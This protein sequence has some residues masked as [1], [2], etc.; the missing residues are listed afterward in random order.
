VLRA[1]PL[2]ACPACRAAVRPTRRGPA[3][4]LACAGCGA[5]Y[6]VEDGIPDLRV[7]GDA[8]SETVRDFYAVAPFPGYPPRLG[9]SGLRARAARS[10]LA[11]SLDAAIPGDARVLEVGCGTGQMCLFLASAD[12]IVVGADFQRASLVLG[13]DAAAR[14][15]IPGVHFVETNLLAPGLREAAFDVVLALGV[16]HH[17]ADPRAAFRAIAGLVRPGGFVVVTL[18]HTLAR[19]P[20][21]LRRGVARMFGYRRVPFDPVLRDR[22]AEPARREAWLRD[23]Y[24][25]P[26]EHRHL[27]GEVRAWFD[28]NDIHFL[29]TLPSCLFGAGPAEAR[30]LF[31][32][33]GD[34]WGFEEAMAQVGWIPSLAAEG[35]VFASVGRRR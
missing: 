5:G 28:E 13:R 11:R 8:R 31:E 20:H 34:E 25:H 22:A 32:A 26:E 18:Y 6:A 19:L 16:L 35:G 12:R 29:R 10:D 30:A 15:R 17:T 9:L 21:R 27:V 33:E 4:A 1:A 2:L 24:L 3:L 7:A 23:Q 14:L